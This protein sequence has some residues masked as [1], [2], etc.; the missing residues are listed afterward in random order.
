[1]HE[2]IRKWIAQNVGEPTAQ[3]MRIIHG[4]LINDKNAEA[5]IS[6]KDID[7]FML[8]EKAA[9]KVTF[10]QISEIVNKAAL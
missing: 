1:M 4:G 2:Y 5:F 7:G 8:G 9:L 6:Q 10:G 3:G